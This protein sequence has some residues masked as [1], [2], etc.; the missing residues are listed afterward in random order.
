MKVPLVIYHDNCPDGFGA[1]YVAYQCFRDNAEYLPL[2][3]PREDISSID[4]KDRDVYILDYSFNKETIKYIRSVATKFVLLDHHQ[5]AILELEGEEGCTFDLKRSGAG[6]AWRYF[7]QNIK[8]PHIINFVESRDLNFLHVYHDCNGKEID[9]R[10]ILLVLDS[11][12]RS[13]NSWAKFDFYLQSLR[14]DFEPVMTIADCLSDFDSFLCKESLIK[15]HNVKIDGHIV[16]A[17]NSSI[18]RH[19]LAMILCKDQPFGCAYYF[20]GTGYIFSLRTTNPEKFNVRMI[21]EKYGGGGHDAAS[22]FKVSSLDQF[23][24]LKNE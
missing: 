23:L 19:E 14:D 5:S 6:L 22:A 17:V 21:A 3:Y 9:I 10:K 15:K 7:F 8:P 18:L 12:G 16:P 11:K 2:S 20:D 13:F 1:A 4:F 24:D